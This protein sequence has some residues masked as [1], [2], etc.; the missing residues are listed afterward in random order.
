MNRNLSTIAA[1]IACVLLV[2]NS[3]KISTI[4][5]E[6]DRLR[7]DMDNR[8]QTMNQNI[9][10][11]YGNVQVMLEEKANLFTVCDWKYGDI[12]VANRTIEVIC[13][14]VPKMYTPGTT[15]TAIVCN[16]R[17]YLLTYTNE[18][19][20]VTIEIP[21]FDRSVISMVKL[22]DNG[23]IKS[24]KLDWIMEPRYEAL[25]LS[26]AGT[27]GSANGMSVNS[28]Y[29]WSPEYVV[30]ISVEQKG[31]F[32]I[33]SAELVEIL[34][35][36]EI[37]RT[38]INLSKE[39][40]K[41]YQEA[42]RKTGDPVPEFTSRVNLVPGPVY[43]GIVHFIYY[44][45]KDYYIPNG[46]MIEWYVDIVDGNGLRYRS[47][48]ECLAVTADGELDELRMEEKQVFAF[49]EAIMIFDSEDNVIYEI[50][51]ELFK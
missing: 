38:P 15:Q 26:Y 35:G 1:I 16:G 46:S 39:G 36:K 42:L 9:S 25:L 18:Q 30:T 47:F 22:N 49:A 29:V 4:Q 31:E 7:Y 8:I 28:E 50:A 41:S 13:N 20:T 44:L 37:N 45:N 27:S 48:V 32:K 34:D 10:D 51:S 6:V 43:E 11:I 2:F 3:I 24:Q 40:Q 33:Q 23:T 14:V 19:F 5:K 21:L 17:E 12:N